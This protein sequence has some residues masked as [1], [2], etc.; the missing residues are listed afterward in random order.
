MSR[1]SR[2]GAVLASLLLLGGTAGAVYA[3]GERPVPVAPAGSG[4]VEVRVPAGSGTIACQAAPQ[5]AGITYDEMFAP[6]DVLPT[7][8][9]VAASI[10]RGGVIG[11]AHILGQEGVLPAGGG[12]AVWTG[13]APVTSLQ[14]FAEPAGEDEALL[15]AGGLWRADA[16]DFRGLMALPCQEPA[17]EAWLVGG[18]TQIG[19]SA[20]LTVTNPGATTATLQAEAWG[21]V[22]AVDLTHVSGSLV[23]PGATETFLLEAS[24]SG[25]DRIAVHLSASGADIV[26]SIVD[27]RLEGITPRGIDTVTAGSS[28][29]TDLLIPAISLVQAVSEDDPIRGAEVLLL[30]NPGTDVATVA[31]T[32]LGPEGPL[33]IPGAEAV[34]VDPGAVYEISLAGLPA[35]D[36]ALAI[37]ADVP[38]LAAAQSARSAGG[39]VLERAWSAATRPTQSQTLAM[40]SPG[41]L[42]LSSPEEDAVV[43]LT[44]VSAAGEA[45]A[46]VEVTVPAGGSLAVDADP[47]AVAYTLTSSVPVGAAAVFTAA[48]ADGE[49][50]AILPASPDTD[51]ELTVLVSVGER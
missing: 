44:G 26:A 21:P 47:A 43:T 10:A 27:T 9:M 3:A 20:V 22:G 30:A 49:I 6:V 31:V 4:A 35:G 29:A 19:H 8:T 34:T 39:G 17:R 33:A 18:S 48:L 42:V 28:P 32:L 1:G 7:S 2:V 37:S 24:A 11:E 23:A 5:S 40:P 50:I 46:P 13:Q 51:P 15:A 41:K 16:G 25:L 12:A 45:L 36:G 14:M 38:V